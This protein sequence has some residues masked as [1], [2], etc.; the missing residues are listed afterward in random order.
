[1]FPMWI[2]CN[3]EPE[4]CFREYF[5]LLPK[6]KLWV[7]TFCKRCTVPE[8]TSLLRQFK[9]IYLL[10]LSLPFSHN[11]GNYR[12]L[13]Q[14]CIFKPLSRIYCFSLMPRKE[15]SFRSPL[16][17]QE[18]IPSVGGQNVSEISLWG[19]IASHGVYNVFVFCALVK[20]A[21]Q[22]FETKATSQTQKWDECRSWPESWLPCLL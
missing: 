12:F 14:I 7:I 20:W 1:M 17:Q 4:V 21:L 6:V 15:G 2:L 9:L 19:R 13:Y 10:L 3:A 16:K 8:F 5:L 18:I 22:I 11:S